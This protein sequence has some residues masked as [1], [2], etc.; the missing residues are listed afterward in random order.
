MSGSHILEAPS[1][2]LSLYYGSC[3]IPSSLVLTGRLNYASDSSRL[4]KRTSDSPTE[5]QNILAVSQVGM[6]SRSFMKDNLTEKPFI[7]LPGQHA[8]SGP[9]FASI[10]RGCTTKGQNGDPSRMDK[11][12]KPTWTIRSKSLN[13]TP[14]LNLRRESC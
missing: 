12:A 5:R 13:E 9:H 3:T 11:C 6:D 2:L 7:T 14:Q 4:S 8:D 10:E 1:F